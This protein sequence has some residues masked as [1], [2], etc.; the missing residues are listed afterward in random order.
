MK[1]EVRIALEQHLV[2]VVINGKA[3]TH[4]VTAVR[5]PTGAVEIAVNTENLDEKLHYI[6]RSYDDEMRLKT[7]PFVRMIDIMVIFHESDEND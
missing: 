4:L 7:S 5:L 1:N 2:D 3:P 6:A